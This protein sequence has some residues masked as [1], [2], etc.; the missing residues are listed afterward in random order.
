MS[1]IMKFLLAVVVSVLSHGGCRNIP[2]VTID[3]NSTE[4]S[5]A[6]SSRKSAARSGLP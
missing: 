4:P 5:R 2:G 3:S 1:L 6:S